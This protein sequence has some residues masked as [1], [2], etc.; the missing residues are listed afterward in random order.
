[1][2]N[3]GLNL[4]SGVVLEPS[5]RDCRDLRLSRPQGL[6]NSA[7]HVVEILSATASRTWRVWGNLPILGLI[8]WLV[9]V[10][11]GSEILAGLGCNEVQ[12]L[13]Y[14][15]SL[16]LWVLLHVTSYIW[17]WILLLLL[18]LLFWA[19]LWLC[20]ELLFQK[21]L[22]IIKYFKVSKCHTDRCCLRHK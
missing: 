15:T 4:R 8:S 14:T 3:I 1:M 2:P 18:S 16:L 6:R 21:V 12:I 5:K 19:K 9:R 7:K 17:N 11:W 20:N 10:L 13:R 22:D